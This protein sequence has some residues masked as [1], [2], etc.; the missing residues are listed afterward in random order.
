MVYFIER[1]IGHNMRNQKKKSPIIVITDHSVM[2]DV[3]CPGGEINCL[4][5]IVGLVATEGYK[6]ERQDQN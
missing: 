6:N 3:D 2:I 5:D 1:K 4:Q